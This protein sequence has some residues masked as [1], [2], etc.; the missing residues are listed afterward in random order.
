MLRSVGLV[1]TPS[2][3]YS[4]TVQKGQ[5]IASDPPAG[6]P[7]RQGDAVTIQVSAGPAP[8]P[9][10]MPALVGDL[11]SDAEATLKTLDLQTGTITQT[12]SGYPAGYVVGTAPAANSQLS[13]GQSVDLTVSSGCQGSATFQLTVPKALVPPVQVLVVVTDQ[14]P[15]PHPVYQ[16]P[17]APG[18]TITVNACWLGPAARWT[19]YANG[20]VFASGTL[21]ASG[22]N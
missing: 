1:P 17:A 8:Q 14:M 9:V 3:Q 2:A 19:A 18:A 6:A 5:V 16:E 15:S 10:T 22:A 12:K 4:A 11:L 13:P 20:N 7:A 21:G